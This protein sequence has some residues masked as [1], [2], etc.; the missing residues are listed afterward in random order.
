MVRL[1]KGAYWDTEIK[2]AQERGLAG[3]PVFTRKATTDVSY[4]ACARSLLARGRRAS[5]PQFATHNAHT[6]AAVLEHGRRRPR[7]S[8]SSAC[9]AWARRSTTQVVGE[10]EL[11]RRL[12]HL[13]AGRQP[14]D[15]LAYLVRRL[16]ENGANS[17]FVNRIA[18]D[19]V[20]IDASWSPTR[21][22]G[23]RRLAVHA[24]SG[25]PL[26]RDLYRPRARATRRAS[27][28]ADAA[29]LAALAARHGRRAPAHWRAGPLIAGRRAAAGRQRGAP[30]RP[31]G[32]DVVG[33]V[34]QADAATVERRAGRRAAA[35]AGLGSRAG[36]RARR[37][38][39]S[40]PPT[41]WSSDAAELIALLRAR[42]RQDPRRR[43]WPKCARRSTSALLR[44]RRR[45]SSASPSAAR[46]DRR[47]A[48]S[49]RCAAAACSSASARG[50]FRWRSSSARS[51]RRWPP[52][53]RWSPSRPSRRR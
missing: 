48:T 47:D 20:P 49:C 39:W 41:C 37:R 9:T 13:C 26:P 42:G 7:R 11:D 2:R 14:R 10:D 3:Y 31:T 8:S 32:A 4:L 38:A 50:I 19:A 18:D 23:G 36:R 17:S 15:L 53:T 5:I 24:A 45:A 35:R 6:V 22:P 21:S 43:A 44:R 16:L 46:P 12:P 27:T 40:A 29:T 28:S 30:T 51:P 33:T 1:V 52:A 25:I 34:A